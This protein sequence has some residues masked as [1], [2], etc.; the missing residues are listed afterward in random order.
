MK[1][2]KPNV[3]PPQYGLKWQLLFGAVCEAYIR[4]VFTTFR[5]N[6]IEP[7]LIKGWSNA[8]FYPDPSERKYSDVDIVVG[9]TKCELSK[10]IVRDITGEVLAVDLHCGFGD[11]DPLSW[12]DLYSRSQLV[13]LQGVPVRVLSDEDNLRLTA[14]HW[15]ID[16][17]VYREHLWDVYHQVANRKR[18]FDWDRCLN[19]AGPVRRTWVV[20][21]IATARDHLALDVTGLPNEVSSFELPHWYKIALEREWARGPYVRIPI[22]SCIDKPKILAEQARRRFPPNAIAATTDSEGPI[23][24]TRRLRYQIKSFLKKMRPAVSG[25]HHRLVTGR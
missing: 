15:L 16:G 10:Q 4:D 24:E 21:A 18:E 9:P 2:E 14:A 12:E 11:R 8:R 17:A 25:I 13:D 6:G 19:A 1:S 22:W 23:D 5:Q 20:A 3:I 7:I